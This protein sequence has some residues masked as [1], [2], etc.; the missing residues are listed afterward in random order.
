MKKVGFISDF[1][2]LLIG[3]GKKFNLRNERRNF[4]DFHRLV[5]S[6]KEATSASG[7]LVEP[8]RS[9][10]FYSIFGQRP[11][12]CLSVLQILLENNSEPLIGK[13]IGKLLSKKFSVSSKSFTLGRSYADRVAKL[14]KA[15][16]AIGILEKV[17][18]PG[19]RRA[20]GYRIAA[21]NFVEMLV[22]GFE[23]GKT[24]FYVPSERET[25]LL[26]LFRI[27]FDERIGYVSRAGKLHPFE[28]GKVIESLVDP[29]VGMDFYN[30]LRIIT[31][32]QQQLQPKM[33]TT[34][35]QRIIY[36]SALK[37]D[38]F[39]AERYL[40]EYTE[41]LIVR[42]KGKEEI[43]DYKLMRQLISEEAY[44]LTIHSETRDEI[45]TN[46][47]L[48]IKK[49]S[50]KQNEQSIRESLHIQLVSKFLS[51]DNLRDDCRDLLK[52][53]KASIDAATTFIKSK[54]IPDGTIHLMNTAMFATQLLLLLAGYLPFKDEKRSADFLTALLK[55]EKK[56]LTTNLGIPSDELKIVFRLHELL[57]GRIYNQPI[58][59]TY[60]FETK[61]LLK[62][63]TRIVESRFGG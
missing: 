56:I 26:K 34:E 13:N 27:L 41:P 12:T 49:D 16:T 25:D 45:I 36:N 9:L 15:L 55:S 38:R 7:S 19:T 35:L 20:Q 61:K 39:A 48:F 50:E 63:I 3:E 47:M 53:A 1:Q 51:V 21:V 22:S 28:V 4:L 54:D 14:L 29:K 30:A 40:R 59:S 10:V 44:G 46:T 8:Y 24:I 5:S 43:F 11:V 62:A 42:I 17:P 58:L 57:T 18:I 60:A 6:I 37:F 52:N 23:E 33:T 31:E 2:R 32:I